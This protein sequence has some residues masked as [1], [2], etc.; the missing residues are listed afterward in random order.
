MAVHLRNK[1]AAREWHAEL[2][3]IG[4]WHTLHPCLD[5]DQQRTVAHSGERNL[6]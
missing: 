4:E 3:Y 1:H 6:D 2:L 5:V